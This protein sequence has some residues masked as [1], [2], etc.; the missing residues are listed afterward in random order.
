MRSTVT[1]TA[2]TPAM[3]LSRFEQVEIV[4]RVSLKGTALAAPG[5]FEGRAGPIE[6]G[7]DK[8]SVAV[9]IDHQLP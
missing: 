1:A 3:T 9:L 6:T 7:G 8:V 4:A 2:M 5:D